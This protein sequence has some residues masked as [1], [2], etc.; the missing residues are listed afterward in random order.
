MI[1]LFL[2]AVLGAAFG[3]ACGTFSCDAT[4]CP[5]GCCRDNVCH[6]NDGTKEDAFKCGLSGVACV[7]CPSGSGC[8][9]GV[10]GCD[11][12]TCP[13]GCCDQGVCHDNSYDFCGTGGGQ[14]FKC[15]NGASCHSGTCCFGYGHACSNGSSCCSGSCQLP[16]SGATSLEC[17]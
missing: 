4:S 2:V 15:I 16:S 3:T 17:K 7:Q 9:K 8:T 1:R 12:S 6:V 10:C 13:N 11:A 14:C 5:D